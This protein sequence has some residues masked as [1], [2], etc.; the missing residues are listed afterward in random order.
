MRLI[1]MLLILFVVIISTG[2]ASYYTIQSLTDNLTNY[3][4][5]L[6][7][8]IINENW[9]K[10]ENTFKNIENNWEQTET[11]VAIFIDHADLRDLNISLKRISTLIEIQEKKEIL[12]EISVAKD[13]INSIPEEERLLLR[14]V[15]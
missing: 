15:F 4:D 2:I 9:T 8:N 10:A 3:F 1:T 12:P 11:I 5:E 7:K 14:N 6:E 13:L